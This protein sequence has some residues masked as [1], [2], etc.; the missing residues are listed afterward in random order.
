MFPT[1]CG[2][3]LFGR[4]TCTSINYFYR[5]CS[6]PGADVIHLIKLHESLSQQACVF[7]RTFGFRD[8]SVWVT[9]GCSGIFYLCYDGGKYVMESLVRF[10][11]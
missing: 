5:E 3:Q 9:D 4:V 7:K 2:S 8:N 11:Q 10:A 6:V 1:E